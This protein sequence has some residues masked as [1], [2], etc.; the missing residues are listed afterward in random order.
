M[1]CAGANEWPD[2]Q[3]KRVK[4]GIIEDMENDLQAGKRKKTVIM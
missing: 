2:C 4:A 1:G 3:R